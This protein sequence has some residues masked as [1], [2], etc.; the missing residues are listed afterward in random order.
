MRTTADVYEYICNNADVDENN[1]EVIKMLSAYFA[2][3]VFF[4]TLGPG[5]SLEKGLFISGNIGCGKTMLM[6]LLKENY[7]CN[8][9]IKNCRE[10][11]SNY[12]REGEISL[13]R[14][15]VEERFNPRKYNRCFDDLGTEPDK[16]YY[17]SD[18]N[19]MLEILLKRYEKGEYYR[20]HVTT[21]LTATEL[22]ERYGPRLTSRFKEMFNF[23][24]FPST[25]T[26]R[27]K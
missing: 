7:K 14:Y 19:V 1:D 15:L 2:N 18:M 20:T 5:F 8:Y 3:D 25:A 24:N 16:K 4:E 17:G 13:Q 23:I 12:A 21:N 11:V 26:D 6:T 10:I 9:W 22:K 27:R